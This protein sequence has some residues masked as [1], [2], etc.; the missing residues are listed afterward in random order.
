MI[1]IIDY[2]AGNLAPIR[3][4]LHSLNAECEFSSDPESI[5]AGQQLIL[6][7]YRSQDLPMEQLYNK[8]V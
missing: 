2:G 1:T 5:S 7:S 4:M 6:P 8:V 3:N